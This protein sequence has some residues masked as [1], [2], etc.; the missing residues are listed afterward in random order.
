M[1]TW[2]KLG[3]AVLAI[4]SVAASTLFYLRFHGRASVEAHQL[5]S[6]DSAPIV[7]AAPGI[8]EGLS[9]TIEV[10]SA[11]DGILKAIYVT[12][13]Q[14]VKADALMGEIA[15]DDLNAALQTAMA[16]ADAARQSRVRL[17]RGARDEE[18]KVAARKTAAARAVLVEVKAQLGRQRELYKGG[19]VSRA[20]YDRAKRDYG[21][22]KAEFQTAVRTELL[23]AAPP[24]PE[25][26]ARADAEVLAAENRVREAQE[27]IK[28]CTI[29][30]PING[31]VL[32]VNAKPGESFSTVTPHP[33]FI[34][35]D[36]SGRRVKAEVDERDISKVVIG[37]KVILRSEGLVGKRFEGT[38]ES[39]SSVMGR[40]NVFT[41]DPADK[42]DRDVL[43]VT[44]TVS[45]DDAT[46]L[47][48]GLRV[49]V[50][51]LSKAQS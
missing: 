4:V 41:D 37:Q 23:L 30:A 21:V 51:F 44:I 29:R 15:C 1:S 42:I 14:F 31:T 40:K 39:I 43:E 2:K 35:A 6:T 24:L 10:G 27:R 11:A 17:L 50:Q 12:E 47:P 16:E 48:I 8:I 13:D 5:S 22:A 18:K 9:D 20:D 3:T 32:R 19:E 38:V 25:D 33:L 46:S 34:L 28:K 36:T 7:F 26:K 49:T 45:A